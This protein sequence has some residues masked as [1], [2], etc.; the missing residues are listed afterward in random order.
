VRKFEPLWLVTPA[1]FLFLS[2]SPLAGVTQVEVPQELSLEEAVRIAR[3]NNPLLQADLNNRDVSDWNIRASYASLIPS[4]SVGSG[5]S[6]QGS[7]EQQFGSV[8]LG[9][10]GF[11]N[12]PSYY[13]SSYNLGISYT[14]NGQVLLALP[15]AKADREAQIAQGVSSE[16]QT[17]FQVTQAYLE[18]LRQEEGLKVAQRELERARGNLR[19]AQGQR[20]VGSGTPMD[21]RQAE[22]AV[23]RARVNVLTSENGVR[24]AKFRLLQQMGLEPREGFTLTSTFQLLEPAWTEEALTDLALERNP[25]LVGLRASIRTQQYSTRMARSAYLPT[26]SFSAGLSA[27]TREASDPAFLVAQAQSSSVSQIEQCNRLNELYRRLA[28]PLPAQ[29]CSAFLFT[30]SQRQ[31]IVNGNDNFPFGFTR[32]PPSASLMISLPLFQGLRRQREVE[33]ARVAEEDTRLQLRD[34]EL[35]LRADLASGLSTLRTAYEAALIEEENQVWANEQLRLA[36]ERYRLGAATFL[37]LGEAETVKAQ[38]DREFIAA[39]F[40]YHDAL[41]SLEALVGTSLRDR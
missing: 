1:V 30:E 6:W 13:F 7:G 22:V 32:N 25:Q 11:T 5:L 14:L 41:A 4:A 16:T 20:E 38:A 10:L 24:I 17:A 18:A 36:Q 33:V 2:I 9:D 12:Q 35:R 19:L 29:D 40:A 34:Q 26:L 3:Q 27:F 21:E 37:E 8:T 31:A 15:Q 39:I 28:D 23:G